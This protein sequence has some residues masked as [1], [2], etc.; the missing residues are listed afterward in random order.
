MAMGPRNK[1]LKE[2]IIMKLNQQF[3][4]AV[5][6][7]VSFATAAFAKAPHVEVDKNSVILA[8]YDAVAYFTQNEAVEATLNLPRLTTVLSIDLARQKT[9]IYLAKIQPNMNLSMVAFVH[10][11][12]PLAKSLKSMVKRSR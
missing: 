2:N 5:I 10:M 7:I 6:L 1:P 3:I 12:Q 4:T 11:A 9:E 8:G